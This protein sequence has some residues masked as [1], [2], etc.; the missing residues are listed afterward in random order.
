ME[1]NKADETESNKAD[2]NLE[3]FKAKQ[4]QLLNY[5][6]VLD[7]KWRKENACDKMLNKAQS[8]TDEYNDQ[9]ATVK[10]EW[11][12]EK[13]EKKEK[14]SAIEEIS[15]GIDK[16]KKKAG[17]LKRVDKDSPVVPIKCSQ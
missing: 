3:N 4:Q 15:A 17:D 14:K 7:K 6:F 8:V 11:K 12:N 16:F 9:L 1:G 10:K 13:G 2:E 5:S